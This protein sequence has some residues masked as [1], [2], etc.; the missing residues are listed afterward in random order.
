MM[1]GK[2]KV[3]LGAR[4]YEIRIGAGVLGQLGTL[5]RDLDLGPV[6]LVVSDEHV[7]PLYGPPVEA[8]LH[9][10][11]FEVGR[12]AVPAGE[13]SKSGKMLFRLYDEAL[14]RGL[15]RRGFVVALG[16]GVVGDLAGFFA[17]SFLRGI[18][19]VQIPT[20]LLA[21][22]DSSVGGKT[23]INLPRGKNLVGAFHQPV[24]VLADVAALRTLPAREYTAGLAEVVKYGII[25]DAGFF[26]KLEQ[27]ADGL[28]AGEPALLESVIAHGCR[29]KAEV[30]RLDERERSLRAILNFGHTLGHAVEQVTGYGRYLHG[31]AISLGM[32][33]AARLSARLT[34]FPPAEAD[35]MIA[36]LRALGLPVERPDL[37]W[38]AV[39]Q[40]MGVDKKTRDRALRFV[41]AERIGAVRVGC[42]V[43][44]E[45]L[46][47]VWNQL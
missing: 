36:L 41:L 32:A 33:F 44:E 12:V 15:D 18:R 26:E 16:G 14:D 22:V 28:R 2:I 27:N 10:A 34:G 21:M 11:G 40:A 29:I 31:E 20:S 17:A 35:R 9:E 23:G 3:D 7:N 19:Y 45:L 42:E 1:A 47:E 24:L 39:R 8:A 13:A 6:A 30:V 5:C 25:R 4:S 46:R 38:S 43:P 37:D